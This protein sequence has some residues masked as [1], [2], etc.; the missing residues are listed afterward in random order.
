[1]PS[2]WSNREGKLLAP[3]DFFKLSLSPLCSAGLLQI[4][5]SDTATIRPPMMVWKSPAAESAA[6]FHGTHWLFIVP[7]ANLVRK[8]LGCNEPWMVFYWFFCGLHAK[9]LPLDRTQMWAKFLV[10]LQSFQLWNGVTVF[11]L[12][13]ELFSLW[14]R[15]KSSWQCVAWHLRHTGSICEESKLSVTPGRRKA[16]VSGEIAC[17]CHAAIPQCGMRLRGG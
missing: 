3:K 8:L 12:S 7:S 6:F 1:M 14:V 15:L 13:T 17:V 16:T 4:A 10:K 2:I 5:D 9:Y 11:S